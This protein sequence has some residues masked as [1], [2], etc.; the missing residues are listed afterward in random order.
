MRESV[1]RFS[2]L[3]DDFLIK[4]FITNLKEEVQ[5]TGAIK[6]FILNLQFWWIGISKLFP[7]LYVGGV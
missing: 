7:L 3:P 2:W 5:V 6:S 4:Y 1:I